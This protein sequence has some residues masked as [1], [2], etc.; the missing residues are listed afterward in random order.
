MQGVLPGGAASSSSS[1]AWKPGPSRTCCGLRL[2]SLGLRRPALGVMHLPPVCRMEAPTRFEPA[3]SRPRVRCTCTLILPSPTRTQIRTRHLPI[4]VA[5]LDLR[6]FWAC[7][8]FSSPKTRLKP[9]FILPRERE[10]EILKCHT[11]A[12]QS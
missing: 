10:R 6:T 1:S 7:R 11:T 5:G 12:Q 8:Y 3:T 2:C 4:T 9:K